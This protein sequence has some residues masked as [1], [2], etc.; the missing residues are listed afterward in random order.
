MAPLT[1]DQR[2]ARNWLI[3]CLI[4]VAVL[5]AIPVS[6]LAG[7]WL[8]EYWHYQRNSQAERSLLEP[9]LASRPARPYN[10]IYA[11]AG[12]RQAFEAF[13]RPPMRLTAS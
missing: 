5:V 7:A 3:G 13:T 9:V 8:A 1:D 11:A 10:R 6:F 4:T 2:R 12:E